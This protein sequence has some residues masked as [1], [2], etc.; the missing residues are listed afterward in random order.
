MSM[1]TPTATV[2]RSSRWL[3]ALAGAVLPAG[4]ALAQEPALAPVSA[5]PLAGLDGH[6]CGERAPGDTRPRIGLALGGGGARGIA[7]VRVLKKL[8]E[9]HIPVDCIAGT[10]AG[11]LVGALY[12]AGRSPQQ[13]E[14]T[15]LGIDWRSTFTDTLPRRERTLRRKS[16]DYTRLAPVGVGF[17]GD[18]PGARLAAGMSQGQ[19]LIAVFEDATGGGRVAGN[20]NDLPIPFRAV[21][22]D[23]NTGQAVAIEHGSLAMAM[24]ASMSLPG[25]MRP[26][27]L[28]GRVLLDGGI[29][30]QIPIDVVRAMG[31]ERIIAVDVGTPLRVLGNDASVLDV[32]DQ[33]SGFLTVGSAQRQL[34]T[35]GA[36]DLVIRPDLTGRV[37]TGEFEKAALAL[38]IGQVA[39]DAAAP[40]L[41]RYSVDPPTYAAFQAR[42]RAAL[43][44]S[45]TLAFVRLVNTTGYSDAVLMDYL[46]VEVG[47]PLDVPA[48]Q[49][50]IL[51]AYGMG[52]LSGL[53]YE[54]VR[55]GEQTGLVLTAT[56]KPNG[57]Y[58]L[59]A[60]LTLSND[61]S[62]DQDTNLRAGLRISPITPNGAEA[63][64]VAQIGSEP[65]LTGEYYAPLDPRN[66]YAFNVLGGFQT[67]SFNIFD[68]G[69][70]RT[71]RYRVQRY[72]GEVSFARN[73]SN[74]AA[75]SIS[76]ERYTGDA[77]VVIGDPSLP[78]L[79]FRQA[80]LIGRLRWDDI[81]SVFFPR[82]GSYARVGWRSSREWLGAD[83]DFDQLDFD[84]IGARSF[85]PHA[86]QLGL[87]YHVTASGV[88]PVES[89]Y[90]LGGRWR[91]AGF[92]RNELTGQD[93]ALGVVG[94]SY[95]LGRVFGRSAQVGATVEYGNAWQRRSDMSLADGIV[96]GSLFIGFDSWIGPLIFGMGMR[97]GGHRTVFIELGQS[98]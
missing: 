64:V 60:G 82:E 47:Q 86:L 76:A 46:P 77:D 31:A 78:D 25:I 52:T 63:R 50:G 9:L 68:G 39:A 1:T 72:G 66:R 59:E 11:A 81:D 56:P 32:V 58:Y 57:P 6:Q 91:L 29:A 71:E 3:L 12:A 62:G 61:L 26:V 96:N 14:D 74:L 98:L 27:N 28:D 87:R 5:A 16:D 36:D 33:M 40:A 45:P 79:H 90:R 37:A 73:F 19:R 24:R 70:N 84:F 18:N 30:N 2:L 15:V 44:A 41:R 13:I 85:G 21:A 23:I 88:A 22:T 95:E 83:D 69:G 48:L 93:Y 8:E 89:L 92:Q 53:T 35:L 17:G 94:Y 75:L 97:E 54:I 43:P 4:L 51:H 49:E 7:H 42:Q 80:A 55:E 20:F 10:S 67:N 65:G 38:E 34:A